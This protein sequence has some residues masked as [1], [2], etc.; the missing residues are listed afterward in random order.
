MRLQ[1][2]SLARKN[3]LQPE[4][5]TARPFLKTLVIVTLLFK[6]SSFLNLP[7]LLGSG[8]RIRG[9]LLIGFFFVCNGK[10]VP[11]LGPAAL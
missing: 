4:Q 11:S 3:N 8:E 10:F 9:E 7:P 2:N 6:C 5:L 1:D